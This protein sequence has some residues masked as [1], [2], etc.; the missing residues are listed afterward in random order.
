MTQFRLMSVVNHLHILAR[1]AVLRDPCETSQ[2]IIPA[3]ASE[4]TSSSVTKKF[5]FRSI[6][7]TIETIVISSTATLQNVSKIFK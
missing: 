6:I 2:F 4:K 3:S 1:G 5:C 7:E